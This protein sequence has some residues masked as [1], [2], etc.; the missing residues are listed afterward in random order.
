MTKA[1]AIVVVGFLVAFAAGGSAG[2][3]VQPPPVPRD[4]GSWLTGELNLTPEQRAQMKEIWSTTMGDAWRRYNEQRHAVKEQTQAAVKA[5]LSNEQ[6]AQ[7]DA[8]MAQQEQK[9]AEL[10]KER[11]DAFTAAREKTRQILTDEQRAR[12]D[13]LT[14]KR[15]EP[16]SHGPWSGGGRS[17]HGNP[18]DAPRPHGPKND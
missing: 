17:Q 11:R 4:P 12:Y 10:N 18:S 14:A 15:G 8:I 6:R 1:K 7:Y 3:L 9:Y 5:L 2:L 13:E 16:G